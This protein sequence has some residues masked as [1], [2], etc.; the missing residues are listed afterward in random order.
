VNTFGADTD[1]D[2]TDWGEV[3]MEE[4][5]YGDDAWRAKILDPVTALKWAME[6]EDDDH[7]AMAF[8]RAFHDGSVYAADEWSEYRY[9]ATGVHEP[10]LQ[11]STS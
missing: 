2:V 3:N 5:A 6:Q 1:E 8:L 9:W 11:N 7:D 10:D 4:M